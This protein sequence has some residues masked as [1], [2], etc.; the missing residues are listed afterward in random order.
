LRSGSSAGQSGSG[1]PPRPQQR[2]H[3]G[4]ERHRLSP[5]TSAGPRVTTASFPTASRPDE[6]RERCPTSRGT[7]RGAR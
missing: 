5:T 3:R 4:P 1:R 2:S 7:R 6:R